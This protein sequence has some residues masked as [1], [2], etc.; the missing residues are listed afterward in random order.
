MARDLV[1]NA[2]KNP[3]ITA[4]R[5]VHKGLSVHRTTI[6]HPFN[7]KE[8]HGRLARKNNLNTKIKYL[9]FVKENIEQPAAFWNN[10]LWTDKIKIELFGN[11]QRRY[12]WGKKGCREAF[13]EI[14][15]PTVKLGGGSIVL[16][17]S[18]AAG[19]TGNIVRV[20]GRIYSTKYQQ[21]L[22]ANVQRSVQ[23]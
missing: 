19:G 20:E 2:Q 18:V 3:H 14:S 21:I 10:V 8:L 15:L 23:T 17:D 5:V 6:Q 4:K 12:V 11:H 16:W 9:K 7:N 13:V 1:R 22:E